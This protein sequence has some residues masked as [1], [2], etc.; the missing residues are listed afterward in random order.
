MDIKNYPNLR[1]ADK[2]HR[3]S[4]RAPIWTLENLKDGLLYFFDLNSRYPT[5]R[6]ID[7]FDYLP[8]SRSIQRSFGGLVE[9]RQKLDL[10]ISNYTTG[11]VRSK[12][13]KDG[14]GRAQV[15][16]E[17]F[18]KYL[19]NEFDEIRVHEHKII[20][21]GN[22]ACDFFIY[23]TKNSGVVIDLFYAKD[24]Y[25]LAR[26]VQ[27]K[28]LKYKD[29]LHRVYFIL[30]GNNSITQE[31]IDKVINNRKIELPEGIKVITE[32]TFQK[33]LKRIINIKEI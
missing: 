15:Y 16:E 14:M 3:E 9:L 24:I 31:E 10:P 17:E 23:E 20:R 4:N 32:D 26:I 29:V 6:E 2:E 5:S 7:E 19:Q 1:K 12:M 11:E 25:S 28:Y 27:I 8:S 33:K 22:T 21:P 13:A 18:L 30:T